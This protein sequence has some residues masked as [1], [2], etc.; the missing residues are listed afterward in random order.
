MH[1]APARRTARSL[2]RTERHQH[3]RR[4]RTEEQ[5][6]QEPGE[7]AAVLAL[8][9]SGVDERQCAPADE[10]PGLGAERL[11][12]HVP[13]ARVYRSCSR[14]GKR[15]RGEASTQARL[16][17]GPRATR[18]R[19]IAPRWNRVLPGTSRRRSTT[20]TIGPTSA[21]ATPRSWPTWRR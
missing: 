8:R 9:E 21:T 12:D 1:G 13:D 16:A 19:M 4:D 20:S 17:C 15:T 14:R 7:P 10:V 2:P 6:E 11:E 3:E 5:R 18:V